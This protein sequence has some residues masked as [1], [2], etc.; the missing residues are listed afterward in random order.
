MTF[1]TH[2]SYK[3]S[4]KLYLLIVNQFT[5][6]ML[7]TPSI[8]RSFKNVSNFNGFVIMSAICSLVPQWTNSTAPS[9]TRSR[10]KW[11]LTSMC[12]FLLRRTGFLGN[13]IDELLS[14][15][16]HTYMK[17]NWDC[18]ELFSSK[19][20]GKHKLLRQHILLQW[21]KGS[22]LIASLNSM[23]RH[24]HLE[25]THNHKCFFYLLY[26]QYN[27]CRYRL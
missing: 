18:W 20:F 14:Q 8:S 5:C 10:R 1:T 24:H 3:S 25:E 6:L 22:P 23:L 13:L 15:N 2:D 21:W 7:Q 27:Q 12:F 19:Y 16:L 26:L 11:N 17:E 4:P 9:L